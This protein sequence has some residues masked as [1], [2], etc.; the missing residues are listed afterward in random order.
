MQ[1]RLRREHKKYKEFKKIGKALIK[2]ERNIGEK[3]NS[4]KIID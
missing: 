2:K 3:Q 4:R 1:N